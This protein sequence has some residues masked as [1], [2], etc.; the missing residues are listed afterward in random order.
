MVTQQQQQQQQ[1]TIECVSDQFARSSHALV[2][3]R[4]GFAIQSGGFK[5]ASSL[6]QIIKGQPRDRHPDRQADGPFT[7]NSLARLKL[8]LQLA[9]SRR[10]RPVGAQVVQ[11]ARV[12][13][14]SSSLKQKLSASCYATWLLANNSEGNSPLH[15][16]GHSDSGLNGWSFR[17]LG[18]ISPPAKWPPPDHRRSWPTG[19]RHISVD[20]RNL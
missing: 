11:L 8:Q 6:G 3:P 13:Q 7:A 19:A 18:S 5:R 20:V 17:S 14:S 9:C 10:V 16:V 1:Q 2:P 4:P 12:V 15:R